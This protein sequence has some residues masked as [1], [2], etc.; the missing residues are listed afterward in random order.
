[1]IVMGAIDLRLTGLLVIPLVLTGALTQAVGP[2][3]RKRRRAM[4]EATDD[5]TGIHR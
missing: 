2:Q 5:V 3:I 1:M 4:R